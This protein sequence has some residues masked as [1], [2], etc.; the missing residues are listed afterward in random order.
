MKRFSIADIIPMAVA[1]VGVVGLVY[2]WLSADAAVSDATST[3]GVDVR[4]PGADNKPANILGDGD[5]I[6]IA[7]VLTK[8]DGVPADL[9]GTWPRLRGPNGDGVSPDKVPLSRQWPEG[10]PRVLWSVEVGEGYAGAAVLGGKVYVLDY[11]QAKQADAVRCLSLTDGKEIWRYSYPVKIKR[12]HGMSRTV[13]A[14]TDKY[15]VTLGPKGHVTCLDANTGQFLWMLNLVK[16][17]GAVI[18]QWYAAQCPL[19]DGDRAIIAPAGDVLMMAVDCATGQIVWKTPNP[20]KWVM[21]HSSIVPMEFKGK[22]FYVYCGGST[23][24]GGV[25]GVSA[26]NG[27]VLWKTDEWKV[28]TNVPVPV[29][30]GEDGIFLTAGYGQ[31]DN[32]C[33]MLRLIESDGRI[34]TQTEFRHAT[35]VFGTMQQTPIFYDGYIY[36]VGMDK[37]LICLDLA[38]K[39]VWAS[40]SANRFGYGPYVIADWYVYVLDD[41]GV[42]T[43]VEAASSGYKPLTRAKV[44]DGLESWGPI[45]VASGR[46]IVR[47]LT[48]MVCLDVAQR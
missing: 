28:R 13:P 10:G 12:F 14:V 3:L 47:D 42:L 23:E 15:V 4:L 40:G 9:P 25:I 22:R 34:A 16:E 38:G 29:V 44:L 8:S 7:G 31:Y 39:V 5:A 35:D 45:A 1:I 21:T 19:I 2:L 32:G 17:F 20:D 24:A 26:T 48:R 6:K 30:V 36:G 11:D 41:S 37:Q 43:L 33:M 18:P 46:L 27:S